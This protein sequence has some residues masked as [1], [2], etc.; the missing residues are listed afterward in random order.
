MNYRHAFHAGNFADVFKH[1]VLMQILAYLQL[2]D[3]PFRVLDTHAGAG[4]YDLA[5]AAALRTHEAAAGIARLHAPFAPA[6]EAVLAPYRAALAAFAPPLYPGSPALIRHALRAEDRA[7]FNEKHPEVAQLLAQTMQRDTRLTLTQLDAYRALK[8]QIPFPERRGLVVIDPAFEAPDEFSHLAEALALLG[9]KWRQASA[10]VWYPVK[11]GPHLAAFEADLAALP[12]DT[13]LVA[14]LHVD[15][16]QAEG[17]LV[18][19][20]LALINPPYTLATELES[21]LP[22]LAE[23]LAVGPKACFRLDFLR[24][25]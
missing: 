18:A 14:E 6:I 17:P 3:K 16:V 5:S 8:A 20:A 24:K 13:V 10:L 25:A 9:R 21:L 23:R 11:Y 7:C 22:A 2:K 4:L 12:F 15:Q 1:A 19:C